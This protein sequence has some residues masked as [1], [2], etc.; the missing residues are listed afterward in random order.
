MYCISISETLKKIWKRDTERNRWYKWKMARP[1][2]TRKKALTRNRCH[3]Q[4]SVFPRSAAILEKCQCQCF[5]S[6]FDWLDF[7]SVKTP[8]IKRRKRRMF[9]W[10]FEVL[11]HTDVGKILKKKTFSLRRIFYRTIFVCFLWFTMAKCVL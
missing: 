10:F 4:L 6:N 1:C 7:L 11:I 9:L 3:R 2:T 8:L 5:L